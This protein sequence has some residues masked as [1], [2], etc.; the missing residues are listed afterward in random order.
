MTIRAYFCTNTVSELYLSVL[1]VNAFSVCCSEL[2]AFKAVSQTACRE[3][4]NLLL[5][6]YGAW[7]GEQWRPYETGNHFVEQHEKCCVH[8]NFISEDNRER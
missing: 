4:C 3:K 8:A 5:D 6:G 1:V 7:F 2:N